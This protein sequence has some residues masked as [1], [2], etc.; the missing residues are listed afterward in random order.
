MLKGLDIVDGDFYN[1]RRRRRNGAETEGSEM[2]RSGAKVER[3]ERWRNS[4]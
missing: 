2:W 1:Q 3:G 4:R